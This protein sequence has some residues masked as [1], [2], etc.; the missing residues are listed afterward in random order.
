[1]A[2]LRIESRRRGKNQRTKFIASLYKA[3]IVIV[4]V[5][6]R[7]RTSQLY[8][9]NPETAPRL[10]PA[11]AAFDM[12]RPAGTVRG[13]IIHLAR[14]VID[15]HSDCS[16]LERRDDGGSDGSLSLRPPS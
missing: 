1:L 7:F 2:Y 11:G 14:G 3:G 15:A 8:L 13:E 12:L 10:R 16:P 4:V 6:I 5:M 9:T